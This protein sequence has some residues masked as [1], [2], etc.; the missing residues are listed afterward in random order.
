MEGGF[1][2]VA[3]NSRNKDTNKV[4]LMRQWFLLDLNKRIDSEHPVLKRIRFVLHLHYNM[5]LFELNEIC[6]DELSVVKYLQ[7]KKFCIVRLIAAR[8]PNRIH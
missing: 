1:I 5:N 2:D 4:S 8:V 7:D 3:N 6:T